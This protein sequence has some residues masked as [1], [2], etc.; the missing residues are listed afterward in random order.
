MLNIIL[1]SLSTICVLSVIIALGFIIK[2]YIKFILIEKKRSINYID[3][4]LILAI[5]MNILLIVTAIIDIIDVNVYLITVIK[6]NIYYKTINL[7]YM[8][9][10]I[11]FVL[12]GSKHENKQFF[13]KLSTL[14]C[15]VYTFFI[16]G[17]IAVVISDNIQKLYNNNTYN[18][19]IS[20]ISLDKHIPEFNMYLLFGY[21]LFG[22]VSFLNFY[23]HRNYNKF[24]FKELSLIIFIESILK[25]INLFSIKYND[26]LF[27][28]VI[29]ILCII[30]V[31][32]IKYINIYLY[33]SLTGDSK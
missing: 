27:T 22:C 13:N 3:N 8:F 17:V 20:Y 19:I 5:I 1:N 7:F 11:L 9:F 4:W 2:Q 30:N 25:L 24:L 31:I 18:V 12:K 33:N 14:L 32:S 26:H 21:L 10:L 15:T 16:F 29:N 23:L 28:I 6:F